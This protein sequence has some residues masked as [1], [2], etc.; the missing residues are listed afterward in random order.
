MNININV[1]KC[2][3][4]SIN[5]INFHKHREDE[6]NGGF[7]NIHSNLD[8]MRVSEMA[9]TKSRMSLD[10]SKCKQSGL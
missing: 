1:V 4:G 2:Q 7:T 5:H 6:S 9:Y 8:L 10:L 3:F